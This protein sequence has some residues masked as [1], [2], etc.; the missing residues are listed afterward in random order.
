MAKTALGLGR[1]C[2]R[3]KTDAKDARKPYDYLKGRLNIVPVF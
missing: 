1:R 3:I 2:E